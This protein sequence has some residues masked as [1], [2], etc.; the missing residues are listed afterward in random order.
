MMLAGHFFMRHI[1]YY[2]CNWKTTHWGFSFEQQKFVAP[3]L[4]TLL[5]YNSTK[6]SMI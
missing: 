2:T 1:A 5:K 3:Q 6:I 4:D